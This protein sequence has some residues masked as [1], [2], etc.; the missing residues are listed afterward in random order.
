MRIPAMA[1]M[2][3]VVAVGGCAQTA[4]QR[5]NR[6]MQS[7][8]T[9]AANCAARKTAVDL[10]SNRE[11]AVCVNQAQAT[12]QGPVEAYGDLM[13]QEMSYRLVLADEIDR[14]TITK[15]EA[16]LKMAQFRSG[17]AAEAMQ[18]QAVQA[19]VASQRA[20]AAAVR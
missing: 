17:L 2:A 4:Q 3:A 18:R 20:V 7:Y 16:N 5:L 19:Q 6:A 12:Y 10:K 13:Q 1:M 8:Y 15:D 14:K 9:A 11:V